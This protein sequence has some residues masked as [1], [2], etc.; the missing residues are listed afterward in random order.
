MSVK[1]GLSY[2]LRLY[3]ADVA[4]RMQLP[5]EVFQVALELVDTLSEREHVVAG[6]IVHAFQRFEDSD[7]PGP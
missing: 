2:C 1:P 5:F 4:A 3:S 7:N 6:R